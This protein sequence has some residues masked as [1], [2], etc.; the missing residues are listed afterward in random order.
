M[1]PYALLPLTTPPALT[2]PWPNNP[3]RHTRARQALH[4]ALH[5]IERGRPRR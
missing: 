1:T 4:A 2:Y 5:T 3:T